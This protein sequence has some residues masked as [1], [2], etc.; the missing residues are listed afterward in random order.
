VTRGAVLIVL[1]CAGDKRSQIR[2]IARAK[3]LAGELENPND[4]DKAI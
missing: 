2:D 1:L 4:P 3:A